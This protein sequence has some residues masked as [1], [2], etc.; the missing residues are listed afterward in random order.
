MPNINNSPALFS[1]DGRVEPVAI[2]KEEAEVTFAF[3]PF[4]IRPDAEWK[5]F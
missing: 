3:W 4:D 1:L 5:R 2:L